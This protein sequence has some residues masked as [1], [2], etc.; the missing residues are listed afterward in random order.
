LSR[1]PGSHKALAM[2]PLHYA[3]HCGGRANAVSSCKCDDYSDFADMERIQDNIAPI[4]Q[5]KALAMAVKNNRTVNRFLGL[6]ERLI[7]LEE[8]RYRGGGSS[9]S[10]CGWCLAVFLGQI[11]RE[12]ARQADAAEM[13]APAWNFSSW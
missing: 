13:R 8:N 4:D 12:I 10:C 2:P 1:K 11:S 3:H 5:R 7:V 9:H 6:L